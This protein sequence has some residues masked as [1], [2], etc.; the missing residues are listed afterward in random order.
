MDKRVLDLFCGCGGLSSGFEQEG[1][2][3]VAG[4]DSWKDAL[5]TF[6][7]NHLGSL[8]IELDLGNFSPEQIKEKAGKDF[9]VI[10]GGPPCQGFSISGK[11]NPDDPRNKLYQGF[12]S[13]V[14]YFKPKVFL[15]ENV[16]NLLSMAKGNVK[17]T[18]V[19]EFSAIGYN[20]QYQV[21]LASDYG[22][23]QNR[24]RVFFIGTRKDIRKFTYPIKNS[25]PPVTSLEAIS[26]LPEH[27]LEDGAPYPLTPQSEYQKNIR[28]SSLGVYNHKVT[29][30]TEQ[31]QKI[32]ALVP[33][34]GNYKNLPIE[35]QQTRK[36]NIAWTRINSSKPSMTID[37]GHNHHFH[38][39]FNRVPTVR[40]SARLQSFPD[41]FIFYGGKTSQLKQVG[42]AVPP[43]L[44]KSLASEIKRCLDDL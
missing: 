34:G 26:D 27:S 20:V 6:E 7:K 31:T 29:V 40:E 22:V 33:D 15:M 23:P 10:I 44:A 16:P 24:K 2:K 4:I 30:H 1:F 42:N 11:R 38:Y 14:E 9:D 36:V 12:V 41:T 21:L 39:K 3:I 19:E 13:T 32:I 37:T 17:D 5:N 43:L 28:N 18:I 25:T 35:L 8:A